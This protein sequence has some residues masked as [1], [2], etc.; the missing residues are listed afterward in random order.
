MLLEIM[1]LIVDLKPKLYKKEQTSITK[2]IKVM[3]ES[4]YHNHNSKAK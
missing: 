3:V 4:P 1:R 2:K